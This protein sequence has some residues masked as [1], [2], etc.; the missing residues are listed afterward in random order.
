MSI[1]I[2]DELHAATTKGKIA[3]AKEV[4]LTGDT[5]NLQQI[6]E[7][8]HQLE[9]SIKN[10]AATGG[11]ST[12]VAVTFDNAASG[13]T[14]VNAQGA[15][16]ELNTKNKTQDTEISKKAN[17]ADVTSQMQIEQKRVN[18]ELDKKA[19]IVDV[20][21]KISEESARIDGQLLTK[22][23]K[24]EVSQ[25]LENSEATMT[26]QIVTLKKNIIDLQRNDNSEADLNIGDENGNVLA[27]FKDGHLKTKEFDSREVLRKGEIPDVSQL[28]TKSE[29]PKVSNYTKQQADNSDSDL[30]IGDELGNII[31]EIKDGHLRT[32]NFDSRNVQPSIRIEGSKL[33]IN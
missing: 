28:A 29:I 11:A 32:K 30:N 26:A 1:N 22:A 2:T 23:G 8:T 25:A 24:E 17:S 13:M 27:E 18:T 12:A 15:I 6:G 3:S 16:E 7:K 14:A 20:N 19:N 9:D 4:F 21:T 31:V 33:I 10:I 5:E